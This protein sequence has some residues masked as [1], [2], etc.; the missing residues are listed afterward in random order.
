MESA[1]R[2]IVRRV[3]QQCQE[4]GS[5]NYG[6]YPLENRFYMDQV[7]LD[8][9]Q[10][11]KKSPNEKGSGLCWIIETD[12]KVAK[13]WATIQ[14]WLQCKNGANSRTHAEIIWPL[15]PKIIGAIRGVKDSGTPDVSKPSKAPRGMVQRLDKRVE[16]LYDPKAYAN[17][18][19]VQWGLSNHIKIVKRCRMETSFLGTDNWGPHL[20]VE[21][22]E[23]AK[24]AGIKVVYTPGGT[25]ELTAPIDVGAGQHI[26]LYVTRC[27]GKWLEEHYAEFEERKVSQAD[28]RF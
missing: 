6:L 13:R 12:K 8:L 5:C 15:M 24:E 17:E 4:K 20:G 21:F 27:W 28:M 3:A 22:R 2:L 1:Q 19:Q 26:K 9:F 7:P 11:G 25:T 23:K 18:Q 10:F 16:H 14:L